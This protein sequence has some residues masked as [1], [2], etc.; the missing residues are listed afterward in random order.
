M[1]DVAAEAGV[2]LGT[3]S[4]VINGLPVGESYRIR[5]EAAI[6][7]LNYQVNSYAQGMKADRTYTVA[8]LVPNTR[9]PFFASLTHQVNEALTRRKYRMLLC[10]TDYNSE[11]EQDCVNMARL[12]KVDGIIGLTYNPDLHVEEDIPF[13]SI[14]RAIGSHIP[15]VASDNFMGGQLA[16]EKLAEFGC[17]NVAFLRIG[18]PLTSEPNKRLSGF[19]NGCLIHNLTYTA[20]ILNDGDPLEEFAE[21]LK[22]HMHDGKLDFDGLFCVTDL[23]AYHII[24]FLRDMGLKVPGDVQVIG[25]DGVQL[26]GEGDYTCSTIVQPVADIAEMCIQLLLQENTTTK[27]PLVCLPVSYVNGGT[28]RE[29]LKT[30]S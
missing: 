12:N 20:K 9:N 29:T 5:V 26:F 28:T 13:V 4:K 2:A 25:F 8:F 10:C 22:E 17:K 15:C 18:S 3:V 23:I 6:K 16:A 1:K 27:P 21:F 24:R 19:E 7:K 11:W 14:D 30:E